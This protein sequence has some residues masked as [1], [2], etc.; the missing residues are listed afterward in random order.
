MKRS[1]DFVLRNLD[2]DYFLI[3]RGR[4][5][6]KINGVLT[7]S[8]TAAFIYNHIEETENIE[9]MVRLLSAHYHATEEEQKEMNE[10][11]KEMF[12]FF[13]EHKIIM[14]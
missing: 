6:E 7:L 12:H 9:D 14:P 4:M 5:A 1:K 2:E 11:V 13:Q 3:P 10:E 8:E